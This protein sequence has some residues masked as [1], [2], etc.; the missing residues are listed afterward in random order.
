MN[1]TSLIDY[2]DSLQKANVDDETKGVIVEC[3]DSTELP[4]TNIIIN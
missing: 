1:L 3:C 2:L 4:D